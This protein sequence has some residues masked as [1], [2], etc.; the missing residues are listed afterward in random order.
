MNTCMLHLF[1]VC[2]VVYVQICQKAPV[3]GVLPLHLNALELIFGLFRIVRQFV[4]RRHVNHCHDFSSIDSAS[5]ARRSMH[6]TSQVIHNVFCW[7]SRFI[8]ENR[9]NHYLYD[10]IVSGLHRRWK[11]FRFARCHFPLRG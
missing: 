4:S 3:V 7:T 9:N 8:R 2:T 1:F 6:K 10:P 5:R 11:F